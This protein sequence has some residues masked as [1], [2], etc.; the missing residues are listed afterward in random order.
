MAYACVYLAPCLDLATFPPLEGN[1]SPWDAAALAVGVAHVQASFRPPAE[2]GA[3]ADA[4][5]AGPSSSSS[6]SLPLPSNP[7]AW[8]L[9]ARKAEGREE[10][11]EEGRSLHFL[12]TL[13]RGKERGKERE[14]EGRERER[15][16]MNAELAVWDRRMRVRDADRAGREAREARE[17]VWWG[18]TVKQLKEELRG[19]GCH[20]SGNKGALIARLEEAHT[21]TQTEGEGKEREGEGKEREGEG[22][23]RGER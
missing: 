14:E 4:D 1:F 22:E 21:R 5:V 17:A 3:H 13:L 19:V 20:V 11:R 10:G 18:M 8:V 12:S 6:F 7:L 15:E 16:A 23:G 2:N 9:G